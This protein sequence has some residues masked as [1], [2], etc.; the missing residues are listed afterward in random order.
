MHGILLCDKCRLGIEVVQAPYCTC[1]GLKLIGPGRENH[2]CG[3]C[4]SG[5]WAFSMARSLLVYNQAAAQIIGAF[6]YSRQTAIRETIVSIKNETAGVDD[7]LV[8]DI[9]IPV[10]LHKK[11]L[12]QRG[13]NQALL[14]AHYLLPGQKQDIAKS[15][16]KRTRQTP[17]QTSL[18]GKERRENIKGA[19]DLGERA[20]V[21]NK[22]ILLIDD[23]FTTGSTLNECAKVLK[24]HGARTV[25]ALTLARVPVF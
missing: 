16:L 6:K 14:L 10:P 7:L 24:K 17:P 22:K 23:V 18:S 21:A 12:Q 20:M 4:L 19:F 2:L 11:R 3:T 1:C 15:I 13:Y 9:I 8:P 5:P 25:Q